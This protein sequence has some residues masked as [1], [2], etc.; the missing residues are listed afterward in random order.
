MSV[1][2]AENCRHLLFFGF[3]T[4]SFPS[5]SLVKG[6]DRLQSKEGGFLD[7][8]DSKASKMDFSFGVLPHLHHGG[9]V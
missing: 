6:E 3:V 5:L 8:T 2:A 7:F 4:S 9:T 1:S